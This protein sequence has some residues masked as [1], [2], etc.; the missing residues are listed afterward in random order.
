MY[1]LSMEEKQRGVVA[2]SA[3]NHAQGVAM[4]A[5]IQGVEATIVMPSDAPNSKIENT[6]ALGAKIIF[7]DRYRESREDI[8]RQIA[9]KD[10]AFLIPAYD[11]SDVICGQGTVGLE[12]F[13]Q[14]AMIGQSLDH[15][16]CPVGGGGLIAGS[17]SILRFLN[18]DT[19]I[20]GVEPEMLNDTQKSME[21]GKREAIKI[22]PNTLCDSL[23]AE[24][25]GELTFSINQKMLSSIITVSDQKVIDSMRLVFNEFG[26]IV[27]PGGAASL[28]GALSAIDQNIIDE[29][30]NIVAVLSGGNI[31]KERH[32]N[33]IN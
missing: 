4:A 24:K 15:F 28:A 30:E 10:K 12:S 19:K 3:G 18:P 25:P 32:R 20:I 27:E 22:F 9:E 16:Y 14:M 23:M 29:G 2:S 33:L 13:H 5:R 1:H 17:S 11:N 31:S 8:A 21:S 6:K 7:Y 26:I